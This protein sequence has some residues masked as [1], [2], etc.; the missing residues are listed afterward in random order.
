MTSPR[1]TVV[2]PT[3]NDEPLVE[4]AICSVL[5]QTYDDLEFIVVDRGSV[6]ATPEIIELYAGE[7]TH[8]MTTRRASVAIAV[9]TALQC[10][11]GDLIAVLD[12]A[13]LY[14]PQALDTVA[15]TWRQT[16]TSPWL[17]GH[18]EL[19]HPDGAPICRQNA[20]P[21][22]S[23][24]QFLMH[25]H[26]YGPFASHFLARRVFDT[27][28]G[29]DT[30][31]HHSYDYEFQCRLLSADVSPTVVPGIPLAA[32]RQPTTTDNPYTTLARGLEN[33][34]TARRYANTAPIQDR[35]RL[36]RN[37]DLR[38]RIFV[39]AEA[40]INATAATG[41]LRRHAMRHPWWLASSGYRRAL[42]HGCEH[43]VPK[44]GV[45]PAA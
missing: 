24:T 29:F 35:L 12:P 9:N 1:I 17:A 8:N 43:P 41:L 5:D 11:T 4:Q 20:G 15:R 21:P 37:L 22:A 40:E 36:W 38:H 44:T 7:L 28:G 30:G 3:L 23:L 2:M 33:I 42:L 27:L 10:A 34:A 14:L 6:D 31:L 13:G 26:R 45:K 18:V 19:T 39:L 32:Y 16:P 25:D